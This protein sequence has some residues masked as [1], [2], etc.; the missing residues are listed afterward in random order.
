MNDDS[1]LNSEDLIS[2]SGEDIS[3]QSDETQNEE[4]VSQQEY[5]VFT[6]KS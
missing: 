6:G 1:K 3:A 4:Q 2:N 5:D